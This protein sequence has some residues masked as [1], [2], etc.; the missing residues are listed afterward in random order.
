MEEMGEEKERTSRRRGRQQKHQME[1]EKREMENKDA[2]QKTYP[3]PHVHHPI[4]ESFL[5]CG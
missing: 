5:L 1:G 3:F 2:I 4:L